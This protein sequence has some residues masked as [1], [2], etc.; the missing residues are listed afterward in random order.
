MELR[1]RIKK[2]SRLLKIIVIVLVVQLSLTLYQ[3][4]RYVLESENKPDYC[5]WHMSRDCEYFFESIGIHTYQVYGWKEEQ[6]L[7]GDVKASA[8]RWIL[9][10]LGFVNI[11]FESTALCFFDPVWLGFGDIR[12]SEGYCA[13][14][15]YYTNK[16]LEWNDWD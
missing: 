8:H 11:P 10:D 16:Q 4:S 3:R 9:I 15:E 13:D 14:G 1:K 5:C 6:G 12:I 2:H 7:A